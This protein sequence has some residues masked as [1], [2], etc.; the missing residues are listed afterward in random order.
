MLGDVIRSGGRAQAPMFRLFPFRPPSRRRRGI[1]D[2]C[3]GRL[4]GTP[5]MYAREQHPKQQ[6]KKQA[7]RKAKTTQDPPRRS[8][9]RVR[10]SPVRL[11]RWAAAPWE[12]PSRR[13]AALG[14][15][16]CT[17]AVFAQCRASARC[18]LSGGKQL[19]STS[20]QR[21]VSWA[22][23]HLARRSVRR[24]VLDTALPVDIASAYGTIWSRTITRE[25]D[26]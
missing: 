5:E 8:L 18:A 13:T 21:G 22:G 4:R 11:L 26:R 9:E 19:P 10:G 25:R 6:H 3:R 15:G 2:D 16:G 7:K 17:S 14:A 20:L 24:A 1:C 12:R 23:R